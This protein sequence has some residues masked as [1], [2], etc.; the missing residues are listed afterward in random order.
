[1]NAYL[2]SLGIISALGNSVGDVSKQLRS[3]DRQ[4]LTLTDQFSPGQALMLGQVD[5]ELTT[6]PLEGQ[7]RNNQLLYL[8]TQQIETDISAAISEFGC[9]RIAIILGTSTSGIA[10]TES[11]FRDYAG[12]GKFPD[13]FTYAHQDIGSAAE[14]LSRQLGLTGPAYT[15]S[16]ACSSGARALA[17]G[18]RLLAMGICDAVI[19]GGVDTLCGLTVQGFRALSATSA[20]V[21]NPGSKNRDG[22]NIGEG[23]A[24]FLMTRTPG[25]VKLA[26]VGETSDAHHISA[27]DPSGDGAY[28]AMAQALLQADQK[29][30]DIDYINLHGTGTLQNDQMECLAVNRLFGDQVPCS[31]TKPLTG[32]CLGASGAIEAAICWLLV[33]PAFDQ[34]LPIHRW[35]GVVDDDLAPVAWVT[36]ADA[37]QP[38]IERALSN[39]F[40]FGGN[41]VSLIFEQCASGDVD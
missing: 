20:G 27:P 9:D 15:I 40:A 6:T 34:P 31:S 18:R 1:M 13:D 26:G 33:N 35:D 14:F 36:P 4:F 3:A 32:H 24:V 30:T 29:S 19:A 22:I 41:N 39:S 17:S 25:P 38:G 10:E 11:V 37:H 12:S 8:A 5:P 21:S 28:R 23:A 7:S 16:T 2:N